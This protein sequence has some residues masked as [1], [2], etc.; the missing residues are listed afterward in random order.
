MTW[1]VYEEHRDVWNTVIGHQPPTDPR[2][3]TIGVRR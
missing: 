2:P 3:E 1:H